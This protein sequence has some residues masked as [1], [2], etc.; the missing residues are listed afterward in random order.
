MKKYKTLIT[1]VII[2]LVAAIIF[3]SFFGINIKN[4]Q[5]EKRNVIPDYKMGMEFTNAKE[6]IATVNDGISSETIKDKDGNIV[7]PEEGVEYTEENGYTTEITKI[8]PDEVR[9]VENYKKARDVI[10]EKLKNMGTAEYN[11]TLNEE[12]GEIKI[13]VPENDDYE[14][15]VDFIQRPGSL[16]LLDLSSFEFVFDNSYVKTSRVVTRQGDLEAAVFLEIEPTEEGVAKLQELG[17]KYTEANKTTQTITNEDGTTSEQEVDYTL[18][19]MLNGMSLGATYIDNITYD[20]KIMIPFAVS[21]NNEELNQGIRD[22]QLES[23]I[24]NAG[25]LPISYEFNDASVENSIYV[26][27]ALYFIGIMG[28]IFVVLFVYLIIRFRA[29]GFISMYFQIGFFALMLLIIRYTDVT[30]TTEGIAGMFVAVLV[31]YIFNHI[32][33]SNVKQK[34]AGMYKNTNLKFLFYTL[35]IF[36]IAIVFTFESKVTLASFGMTLFWGMIIT[37]IYNFVFS[38]FVFENL[39]GGK[40]ESIKENS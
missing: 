35:P 22:A 29:K 11:V 39:T 15:V 4:N 25:T 26:E 34:T 38:K 32:M 9:T 23:V 16:V 19:I 21:S 33:L 13:K 17:Q 6:I 24:L 18:Y 12:T 28:A 1:V 20:N 3:V 31:N 14:K 36:I 40:N 27:T 30:L 37:Y 5:G 8:N 10:K 2:L 7:E